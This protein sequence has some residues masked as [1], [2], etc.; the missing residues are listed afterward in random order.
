MAKLT[1]LALFWR[2]F[3]L[4][5]VFGTSAGADPEDDAAWAAARAADTPEAFY[6]YLSRFP[7]G[8]HVD[9]AVGALARLGALRGLGPRES[10]SVRGGAG[11][12]VPAG[13]GSGSGSRFDAAPTPA[14]GPAGGVYP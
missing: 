12:T 10:G 1:R 5:L 9:A 13:S 14:Q 7:A 8:I 3:F 2:A 4:S 11:A 6:L